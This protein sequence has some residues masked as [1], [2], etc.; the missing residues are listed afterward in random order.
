MNRVDRYSTGS[1]CLH[2][3]IA[4]LVLLMLSFG[5]FLSDLPKSYQPSAY[6][7]HKSIGLTI[8]LLMVCRLFWIVHTG[9]PDLPYGVPKWERVLSN[10]VQLSL[11]VFLIAMPFS[12]W[13]M[14]V[15]AERIPVYF[16]LFEMPLFGIPVSKHL[17]DLTATVHT[18]IAYVLISLIGLHI[19][20]ALKHQFIDKDKVMRRMLSDARE[21]FK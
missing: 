11:Y 19:L 13:I 18:T 12:G 9:K 10:I 16:G 3:I 6:M 2:W 7:I 15:A 21:D 4:V 17:S 8:L 1:K 5:F 14:S 20:G